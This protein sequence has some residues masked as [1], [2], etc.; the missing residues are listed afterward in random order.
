MIE[1]RIERGLWTEN[2][3]VT[4]SDDYHVGPNKSAW[5]LILGNDSEQ[6]T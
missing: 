6:R 2:E 3:L 5:P 1:E 4:G